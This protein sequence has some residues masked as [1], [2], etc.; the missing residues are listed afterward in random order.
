MG[1]RPTFASAWDRLT[2]LLAEAQLLVAALVVTSGVLLWVF[3]PSIPALPAWSVHLLVGS[4]VLAPPCLLVGVRFAGWFD[5]RDW[6]DVQH[7][8]AVEDVAKD[9]KVP[10]DVWS[11]KIVEGPAPYPMNDGD[12][13]VVREYEWLPDAGPNG[14]LVVRGC[15]LSELEDTKLLTT[16]SHFNRVYDTLQQS[17]IRLDLFAD[18]LEDM[19]A[20][21]QSRLM[22]KIT[23]AKQR[24]EL[25][26]KNAVTAVVDEFEDDIEEVTGDDLA[27]LREDDV[28]PFDPDDVADAVTEGIGA[29][30]PAGGSDAVTTD[31]GGDGE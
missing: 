10:P 18:N 13:W 29:N 12:T 5:R 19:A 9:Y 1:L 17:H 11:E 2:Y 31:G 24:G 28:D 8:N 26:D 15:W 20:A 3:S 4:L 21:L 6:V 23:E 25:L 14:Q 16:R 22:N 27:D 7:I 30:S